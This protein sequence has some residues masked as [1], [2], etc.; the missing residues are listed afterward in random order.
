MPRVKG[1]PVTTRRRKKSIKISKRLLRFK[2]YIYK[3]ANQAG[4]EIIDVCIP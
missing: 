1:G 4:N 3:V 2:T